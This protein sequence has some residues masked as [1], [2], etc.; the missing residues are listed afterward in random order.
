M[1][2]LSLPPTLSL[3]NFRF[4][5]PVFSFF[6]FP[7]PH[8]Q[9][10]LLTIPPCLLLFYPSL[11]SLLLP[12]FLFL[13]STPPI[14]FYSLPLPLSHLLYFPYFLSFFPLPPFSSI[15]FP[16]S[17]SH[18]T[19]SSLIPSS[20]LYIS[21]MYTSSLSPLYTTYILSYSL[22]LSI[23]LPSFHSLIYILL[24]FSICFPLILFQ[25]FRDPFCPNCLIPIYI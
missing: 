18:L 2:S 12:P 13:L 4:L 6:F 1:L 5:L 9:S 21:S 20:S 22:P 16:Y 24:F 23:C 10:P 11:P 7:S 15:L 3:W 17:L 19:Y 8:S 14:S 25:V